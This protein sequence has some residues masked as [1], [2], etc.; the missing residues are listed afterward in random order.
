MREIGARR[1]VGEV[2][3][4]ILVVLMAGGRDEENSSLSRRGKSYERVGPEAG[5]SGVSY[6]SAV[7]VAFM[8][9]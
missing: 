8:H 6:I 1:A 4:R 5:S 2:R 3:N 9:K 7:S